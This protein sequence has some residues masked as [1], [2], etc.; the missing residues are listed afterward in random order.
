MQTDT[1]ELEPAEEITSV[2]LSLMPRANA[3]LFEREAAETNQLILTAKTLAITTLEEA[4]RV[5]PLARAT[6]LSLR[7]VRIATD[8]RRL[9]LVEDMK[10]ASKRIDTAAKAIKDLCEEEEER[11]LGLEQY[12]ERKEQERVAALAQSRTA[13][14]VALGGTVPELIA[15][16][17]PAEWE[18]ILQD[19]RDVQQLKQQRIRDAEA[20]RIKQ[21]QE[22][23]EER[24]RLRVE[25][26]RLQAEAKKREEEAA[27]Q[28]EEQRLQEEAHQKQLAE[29]KR[30]ADEERRALQEEADRKLAEERR[31][32][33]EKAAEERRLA[34]LREAELEKARKEEERKRLDAEERE[35]EQKRQY[36]EQQARMKADADAIKRKADADAEA[37]RKRAAA[38]NRK[39]ANAPDKD[40]LRAYYAAMA[41]LD[42]P[43]LSGA[44]HDV[45]L[46]LNALRQTHLRGIKEIGESL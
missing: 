17:P 18:Q 35:R 34:Q 28:R 7:Q 5:G 20:A 45:G 30:K 39:A 3:D 43:P 4:A 44:N 41:A 46:R 25:N 6:R 1:T 42:V 26:E 37:E 40:K 13:E 22:D 19:A 10:K 32:R 9:A 29:E 12:A 16:I 23:A 27:A 21:E 2:E 24:E 15:H 31:I 11:L 14:I 33:D 36:D 8:K 38:A